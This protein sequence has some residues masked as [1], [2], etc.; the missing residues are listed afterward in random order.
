MGAGSRTE[1]RGTENRRPLADKWTAVAAEC[2]QSA[3]AANL[4]SGLRRARNLTA[5]VPHILLV[6]RCLGRTKMS[7]YIELHAHSAYSFAVGACSP[8]EMVRGAKKLGLSG[9]AL[10]DYDGVY[11]LM[12]ARAAL[13]CPAKTVLPAGTAGARPQS[14]CPNRQGSAASQRRSPS[15]ASR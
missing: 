11:G 5:G 4:S 14:K 12:E 8:R 2:P 3:G 1:N 7:G 13:I 6:V 9:L 10:L 15:P